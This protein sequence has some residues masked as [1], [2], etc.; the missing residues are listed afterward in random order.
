MREIADYRRQSHALEGVAEYHAMSFIML[1]RGDPRRVQTGV[2][3]A[4]FF[5]MLGVR[6]V[7]GRGFR[8]GEE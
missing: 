8:A 1:G 4:D 3:S 7:L 6:P 5:D 2:V